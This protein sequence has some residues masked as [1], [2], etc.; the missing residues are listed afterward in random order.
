MTLGGWGEVPSAASV[1]ARSAEVEREGCGEGV[2]PSPPVE[3]SG[4]GA[5]LGP[6]PRNVFRFLS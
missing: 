5:R 4:E 3:G 6:I 2:S 1:E